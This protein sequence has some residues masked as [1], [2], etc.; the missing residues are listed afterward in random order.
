MNKLLL[1][2]MI[3]F[4]LSLFVSVSL[5]AENNAQLQ[6][7]A[8]VLLSWINVHSKYAHEIFSLIPPRVEMRPRDFFESVACRS[9]DA[10]PQGVRTCRRVAWYDGG[11]VVYILDTLDLSTARGDSYVLHEL[12]H[13]VQEKSGKFTMGNECDDALREKEAYLLQQEYIVDQ[14]QYSTLVV[15]ITLP[16]DCKM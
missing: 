9:K 10:T 14:G 2:R 3:I 13:W 7:E 11:E 1:S 6:N 4:V 16:I 15:F 12:T 8:K 5:H